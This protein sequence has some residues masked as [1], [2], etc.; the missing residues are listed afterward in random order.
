MR[1]LSDYTPDQHASAMARLIADLGRLPDTSKLT[2]SPQP[3][4]DG[5]DPATRK[6]HA[7]TIRFL[8]D[9]FPLLAASLDDAR[10]EVGI[11]GERI[12]AIEVDH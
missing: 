3:A 6:L 2:V 4:P 9:G 12:D 7:R 11:M 10:R 8:H 5:Y 1:D